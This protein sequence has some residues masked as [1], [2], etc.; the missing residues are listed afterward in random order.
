MKPTHYEWKGKIFIC[1][2]VQLYLE[3]GVHAGGP[4]RVDHH[5][6]SKRHCAAACGTGRTPS[7]VDASYSHTFQAITLNTRGVAL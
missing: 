1:K 5:G 2:I 3:L 6:R 7:A 4:L